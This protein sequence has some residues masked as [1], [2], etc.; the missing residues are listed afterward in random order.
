M[1]FSLSLVLFLLSGCGLSTY[2]YSS[3]YSAAPYG[4]GT[5]SEYVSG[6]EIAVPVSSMNPLGCD[7]SFQL[8]LRNRSENHDAVVN[9][10]RLVSDGTALISAVS[11]PRS[12]SR[13]ICLPDVGEYD[14]EIELYAI[15]LGAPRQ[16]G[17]YTVR[18]SY[19]AF[20]G[21]SGRHEYN[22]DDYSARGG[23]C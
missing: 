8:E 19:S 13:I 15:S 9:I 2:G 18:Q 17:C 7:P 14:L 12:G 23:R 22:I 21:V 11:I 20:V 1:K 5:Q 4:R 6:S 3:R 16:V 10:H